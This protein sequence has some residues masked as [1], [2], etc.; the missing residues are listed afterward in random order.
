[1]S[2]SLVPVAVAC[3]CPGTPHADG[4]TVFLAPHLSLKGGLLAE[5]TMVRV[6]GKLNTSRKVPEQTQASLEIEASLREVYVLDG[7]KDWTFL[8]EVGEK[9]EV[10]EDSI[11]SVL[12]S[13]FTLARPVGDKADE[14]YTASVLDPLLARLSK[15]SPS[16]PRRAST[17]TSPSSPSSTRRPKLLK[18]SSTSTTDKAPQSA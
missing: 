10:N 13:N 17:S 7:V 16:S 3:P 4:D 6:W 14:L 18:P 5:A 15:S 9:V 11:R 2:D 1:M 12:L 8:D